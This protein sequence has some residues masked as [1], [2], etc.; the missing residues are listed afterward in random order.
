MI[1]LVSNLK[2][3][4]VRYSGL[5]GLPGTNTLYGHEDGVS[6]ADQV[7]AV[8]AF[9]TSVAGTQNDALDIAVDGIV[10]IVDS[11]TGQVTGTDDTG[12][13]GS[14]SGGNGTDLLPTSTQL[15]V[16]LR[17]GVYFG[18]RELRGRIFLPGFGE[19]VNTD[20]RPASTLVSGMQAI[21][22]TLVGD[23]NLAVF[24]P[25]KHEWASVHTGVVWDE[26]AVLRSR[27]D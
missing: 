19:D 24:S 7:A 5:P 14:V 18:G 27:R 2:R 25:T 10:E 22:D 16:Q 11:T 9:V 4:T 17:T 1:L 6:A 21:V 26:W 20:G 3:I 8:L 15:L 12:A 13:G 23:A